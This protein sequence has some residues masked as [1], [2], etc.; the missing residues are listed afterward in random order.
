M[1]LV[2]WLFWIF[3]KMKSARDCVLFILVGALLFH[4]HPYGIAPVA[5]LGGLSFIYRPFAP[6]RRWILFAVP[7]IAVLT[8]PWLAL[9]YLSSTGV[10]LN[11]SSP[12]TVGVFLERCAQAF[13]ETTSVT[14][15]IGTFI[16]LLIAIFWQRGKRY[17]A[18]RSK[19][20][21]ATPPALF[22]TTEMSILVSVFATVVFYGLETAITQSSDALWLAGMRY[23]S[24]V[25]P[26]AAMGAGI[27]IAKATGGNWLIWRL[28]HRCICVSPNWRS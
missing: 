16:L 6:Q 9:S 14:P 7:A 2:V 10:E 22:E 17:T 26:I 15:V 25:L 19:S 4:T 8:L 27:V 21:T 13:I 18:D 24:A 23:S 3:F 20:A 11:T 1:L 12:Q 5:A 28:R